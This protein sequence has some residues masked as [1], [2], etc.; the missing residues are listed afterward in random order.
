MIIITMA[1]AASPEKPLHY[2]KSGDPQNWR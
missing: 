2:T 1:R